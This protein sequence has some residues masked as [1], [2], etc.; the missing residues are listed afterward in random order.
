MAAAKCLRIL[1]PYRF[2]AVLAILN[3]LSDKWR[4]F[5]RLVGNNEIHQDGFE[6]LVEKE[7][8]NI[9]LGMEK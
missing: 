8:P 7:M 2:S 9:Y 6:R 1:L 5:A 3:E 4:T